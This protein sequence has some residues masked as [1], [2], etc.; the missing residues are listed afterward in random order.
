MKKSI[1]I[2]LLLCLL[3]PLSSFAV[4]KQYTV[5]EIKLTISFPEE[6]VVISRESDLQDP[7]IQELGLNVDTL[8]DHYVASNIYLNAIPLHKEHEI[9][10]NIIQDE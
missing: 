7:S 3:L 9:V 5:P 4:D 1:I 8:L 2:F 6:Y 10:V